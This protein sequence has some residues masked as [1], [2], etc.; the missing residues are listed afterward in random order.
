MLK[1]LG[2]EVFEALYKK[3]TLT[4]K[5]YS[6]GASCLWLVWEI[7]KCTS[8]DILSGSPLSSVVSAKQD[9]LLSVPL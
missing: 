6:A 3:K 8:N 5:V 1:F 7:F 2:F 4:A 9:T